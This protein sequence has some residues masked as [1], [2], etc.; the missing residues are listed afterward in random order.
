MARNQYLS[1]HDSGQA[2]VRMNKARL[3]EFSLNAM[4]SERLNAVSWRVLQPSLNGGHR[5]H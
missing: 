4:S 1:H 5:P 2:L 3:P